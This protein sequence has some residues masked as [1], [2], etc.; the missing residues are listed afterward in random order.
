MNDNSSLELS[1]S[2]TCVDGEDDVAAAGGGLKRDGGEPE[3][4][5]RSNTGVLT[6]WEC[7]DM[8]YM[9]VLIFG[10]RDTVG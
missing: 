5:W 7:L 1:R 8:E 9:G 6:T 2:L 4:V 3:I 10:V